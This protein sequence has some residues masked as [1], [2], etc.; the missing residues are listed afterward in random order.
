MG[1]R[2]RAAAVRRI[3]RPTQPP[4]RLRTPFADSGRVTRCNLVVAPARTTAFTCRAGCKECGASKSRYAARSSAT[5]CYPATRRC[6]F[7][8]SRSAWLLRLFGVDAIYQLRPAI[9]PPS[10]SQ[11]APV[12][13]LA[14]FDSRKMTTSA[15]SCAVPTRPIGWKLLKP[16]R[17]LCTSA[18]GMKPS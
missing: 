11:I 15:T 6:S 3:P 9:T 14:L 17:A 2:N 13:Q 8:L 1:V 12:T 16:C 4:A 7:S 5:L 18:F 10:T